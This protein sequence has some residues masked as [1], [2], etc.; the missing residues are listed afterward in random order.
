MPP[1]SFKIKSQL[2]DLETCSIPLG[3]GVCQTDPLFSGATSFMCFNRHRFG[4]SN[5]PT[6]SGR[7]DSFPHVLFLS[8]HGIVSRPLTSGFTRPTYPR[9]H[10]ATGS[11]HCHVRSPDP[12]HKE[13]LFSR[14]KDGADFADVPV[15][16]K[17][18][19]EQSEIEFDRHRFKLG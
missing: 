14:Q 9:E 12:S 16:R 15:F 7:G 11:Y 8:D 18:L 1:H 19:I 13:T 17:K 4:P 10:A 5:L 2:H 6:D 3:D